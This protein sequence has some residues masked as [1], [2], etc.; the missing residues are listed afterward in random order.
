MT[1]NAWDDDPDESLSLMQRSTAPPG[2]NPAA[3]AFNPGCPTI[4]SYEDAIQDLFSLWNQGISGQIEEGRSVVFQTWLVDHGRNLLECQHPRPVRLSEAFEHWRTIILQT[5]SDFI[6]PG[7]TSELFVVSPAPQDARVDSAGH[8]LIVLNA[9]AQLV[10]S[11]LTAYLHDGSLNGPHLQTAITTHEHVRMEEIIHGIG[12]DRQCFGPGPTHVCEI[13]YEPY[14]LLPGQRWPGRNGMGLTAHLR[15]LSSQGPIMLQLATTVVTGHGRQIRGQVAHTHEPCTQDLSVSQDA[16]TAM[17]EVQTTAITLIGDPLLQLPTYLEVKAPATTHEVQTELLLWGHQIQAFDCHPHNKFF[18][19]P[20][21]EEAQGEHSHYLFCHQD[22]ADDQGCFAHSTSTWLSENQLMQF[23]CGLG[24]ARAVILEQTSLS[25]TWRKVLFHHQEPL[26]E[27]QHVVPRARSPWPSSTLTSSY[28]FAPLYDLDQVEELNSSC[29]LR[30]NFRK[31]DLQELFDSANDVLCR[32]FNIEGLPDHVRAAVCDQP[33]GTLDFSK[34]DRLLLFTDGSSRPEGKRLPPLQADE[35]GLQDTWAFLVLGESFASETR[36]AV[37]HPIGW[38]AQPVLYEPTARSYTGTQRIGSDQAERA[39]MTFAGLWRLAQ[40]V[41]V[42]TVICTDSITTGGQAFGELGAAEACVS[43][44]LL[45]SIYQSLHFA[46]P[47]GGLCLYPVRAHAG[48]PYNDFVD[49]VAKREAMKTFLHRRPNL[50]LNDWRPRLEHLWMVFASQLGLPKW[51]DG[52]F[53]VPAPALPASHVQVPPSEQTQ[54]QFHYVESAISLATANVQS[55]SRGPQGHGGKL[56]YLQSQMKSMGINCLGIQE[57]RT[58][59]GMRVANDILCFASGEGPGGYGVELWINMHQPIGWQSKHR[60]SKSSAKAFY[61]QRSEF[62]VTHGD[63]RRLLVRCS[64]S[65]FNS[66]IFV[67]HAPHSGRSRTERSEW[68][69]STQLLL[70]QHCDSAPLFWMLDANAAPGEADHL[71]VHRSGF[72][73]STSTPFFRNALEQ[74]SLCLPAT[75]Q[76]HSG[77]NATWTAVDGDSEHCIDHIA[78]PQSWLPFCVQSMVLPDF[79]LAQIN[80]DHKAVVLQLQWT[81][82]QP[83]MSRQS[84]KKPDPGAFTSAEFQ[85]ALRNYQ[86]VHWQVD[87]EAHADHFIDYLHQAMQK[88]LPVAQ[89]KAKKIYVTEEIWQLRIQKLALRKQCQTL[90]RRIALETLK[91]CFDAWHMSDGVSI[92]PEV[93]NYGVSLRCHHVR[94]FCGFQLLKKRMKFLLQRSRKAFLQQALEQTKPDAPASELQRVMKP[95]IGPTN[96]KK[97]KRKTLPLIYDSDY[98]PCTSPEQAMDVWVQFFQQ[99]EGGTRLTIHELRELWLR[100][101]SSFCQ[102]SFDLTMA[103]LPT[104]TDVEIAYRRVPSGRARGPDHIPGEVCHLH[105]NVMAAHSFGQLMKLVLHGQ[106]PLRFKGG[107]LTP[108]WKGKGGTHLVSSYRSLLVSS[109]LGKILHRSVRQLHASTYEHWLQAQQLGGRRHVPVQLA[110]HQ[111]R[112][113]LRRAK[114][115]HASVGLLFLDLTEAFYRI[116]RELT[117]GGHPTDE[118]LAFVLHR[119]QMPEDS[120]PDGTELCD[121]F[122]DTIFGFTW[123]LVLQKLESY[124]E[125]NG[126]IAKLQVPTQPPFFAKGDEIF[127]G[128]QFKS[129]LGPTWMDDLC[130]CLYGGT[131][132]KLERNL[133]ANIGYLLDLCEM[134]LMSPNLSKGKTELLLSFRGVGSR[135]MTKKYHGPQSSG[136]FQVLCEHQMKQVA[137]TKSYRHLGGQLH[138][139]SDQYAEVRQKIAVAHSAY[140]QHRRLLYNNGSISFQKR[141]EFFNT[142]VLTKLLYGADSWVAND[143]R[144]MQRLGAA[145]LRLYQRLLRWKPNEHLKQI[146]ILVACGL[147]DPVILLRHARLRYLVVLFQCGL[148]DVWHLLSEDTPWV[149]LV[150]DDMLWM[151]Q[152]LR[153]SSALQDPRE[154]SAQWFD[155]LQFHPRYWKR[156]VRRA[157]HHAHLQLCK[158]HGVMNFHAQVFSRLRDAGLHPVRSLPQPDEGESLK[159]FGCMGCGLRCRNR[160][161]EAAH[162]FRKHG[163]LSIYRNFIDQT[164]CAVCLKEFHTYGKLKAHLH[165]STFCKEIAL[166][167]LPCQSP[168]PGKGSEADQQ[169]EQQHDRCLP[170]LQAAGPLPQHPRPRAW[171]DV[172]GELHILMVDL[173]AAERPDS[174]PFDFIEF[175][176]TVADW[177]RGHAISWTRTTSTLQFFFD[178]LTVDDAQDMHFDLSAAQAC[179]HRL[180]D[181]STWPF[182]AESKTTSAKTLTIE[183]CHAECEGWC[184][185]L[186]E[187]LMPAVPRVMGRHRIILH[188]FAGRRRIGDLQYFLERDSPDS[189]PYMLTVVSLDII[190]NRTWG[191]ASRAATRRFW[192]SAIRDKHVVGFVAGPPCE[193]WSRVRGVLSCGKPDL[194][195]QAE[196]M[197]AAACAPPVRLPRILRDLK[198]L[199]GFSALAVKELEQILVGNTLLCFALEAIIEVSL[200]GTVGLLEH[201]GEPHDLIDAASIWRLPILK[202]IEQLPG[203][204]R[205]SF[206]QGLMGAKTAKPT[207]FLCVNLPSMMRF[208][209]QNRVRMELPHGQSVGK[210]REGK[211]RTSSLKEYSPALCKAMADAMRHVFDSCEVTAALG[212]PP[213]AF[214]ELC[215]SM[216][217]TDYGTCFGHDY[218]K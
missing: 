111:A 186:Q 110:L 207:D 71:V 86:P 26:Q 179:L 30:T 213:A 112:A 11:L 40:N 121:S 60:P 41:N 119:L 172:D 173:L 198:E 140:N 156:L 137:I 104:L 163:Q 117:L 101:L 96:P 27:D 69:T 108:A 84:S 74:F 216:Q 161:R 66:W 183:E 57:A 81:S 79:D 38:M 124:M 177:I 210:T 51:K 127:E 141:T 67:G 35:L 200:A 42:P 153:M 47:K 113:F 82:Y 37:V 53:D 154:H 44:R 10:T 61:F 218:A 31:P 146:D 18:C 6:F 88:H 158:E 5:W 20:A 29:I 45:R 149:N 80:E 118:L 19:I 171:Q 123:S 25:P 48:D 203:V 143:A 188:A 92:S 202:V 196:P 97:Q 178:S 193:T 185:T 2:L 182:L 132:M 209:H 63:E 99:M 107:C 50:D 174:V 199:W 89:M 93:F 126:T 169:L 120:E 1:D 17:A 191:D 152:Q 136:H 64:N 215:R 21:N 105:A 201:P 147:P 3:P 168:A 116:L 150:E 114:S 56:H 115:Q 157:C 142:L 102:D 128:A 15:P 34:Y 145:V 208:L 175:E 190:I 211:W 78:V 129:Y 13:W 109:N 217:V 165:Y 98:K 55:L 12:F 130:L 68:W 90:R 122:A 144:T 33:L 181:C 170:P 70:Q 166:A 205:L 131:P 49:F 135:A 91:S 62:V 4:F 23:L 7:E 151:W 94:A 28:R 159:V 167:R 59:A 134:H 176:E 164:Q 197:A 212:D 65:L 85:D 58:E 155:L 8:V 195:H 52:G 100:D 39:A 72:A 187:E 75:S 184:E 77:S 83:K 204:E 162:M 103:E 46:L 73:T 214:L 87:V 138:H 22:L 133:G 206:A 16:T 106:E 148:S 9:H 160:A 76:C 189:S 139:T 54:Q 180:M 192:M 14:Q 43:Y 194:C 24:Y 125:A 32:N 36:A 95:F